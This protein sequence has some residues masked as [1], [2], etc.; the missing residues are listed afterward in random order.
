MRN[1]HRRWLA[2]AGF[3]ETNPS[4]AV[5]HVPASSIGSASLAFIPAFD[6]T[7]IYPVGVSFNA[8]QSIEGVSHE[9]GKFTQ[10][11]GKASHAARR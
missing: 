4:A 10:G 8:H 11:R 6:F 7:P 1:S 5:P 9:R 3:P 2:E